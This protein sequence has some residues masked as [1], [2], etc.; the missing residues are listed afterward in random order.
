MTKKGLSSLATALLGLLLCTGVSFAA[1]NVSGHGTQSR[2]YTGHNAE[3]HGQLFTLPGAGTITNIE[4]NG[5]SGFWIEKGSGEMVK[6][7]NTLA[8]AKG[9]SLPAGSYRVIP[10]IRDGANSCG[11]TVTVT[12]P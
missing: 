6:N 10:N 4:G 11:V 1:T 8:E 5:A 2:G 9:Y 12:C 3:I 7:F